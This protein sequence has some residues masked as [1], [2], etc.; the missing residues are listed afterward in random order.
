[1][2]VRVLAGAMF[3]AGLHAQAAAPPVAAGREL[4]IGTKEAQPFVT[5]D[6]DGTF[7]G[8]SIELWRHTADR[9]NLRYRFQPE[10]LDALIAKTASGELDAAIAA[11]TVTAEREKTVDFSQPYYTTG[12]GIA[13]PYTGGGP[14]GF[15]RNFLTA[16]MIESI[17]SVLGV[18]LLVGIIVWLLERRHNEHF[19]NHRAG[20]RSSIMWAAMSAAG[21]SGD[22][23]PRTFVGQLIWLGWMLVSVVLISSFTAVLTSALTTS[24]LQ[25]HI[26]DVRDLRSKRTGTVAASA[27]KAYLERER[28][29]AATFPD[30]DAALRALESGDLDA[31]VYDRPLLVWTV[32]EQFP[33]SLTVLDITF[34]RQ[35]YAIALPPQS[36]LRQPLNEALLE[37]IQ[38]P[39]WQRE[40]NRELGEN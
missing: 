4:V 40:L 33:T 14:I 5:K 18:L 32:K 8:L 9:L 10:T 20:L 38:S 19:G 31:V 6:P 28:I 22:A 25:G 36:A 7:A 29:A 23:K 1:M 27:P 15:V 30:L 35:T 16:S 2:L 17:L 24:K 34:N 11:I 37:E 26:T 21:D 13:V 39:W 3:P 12:L